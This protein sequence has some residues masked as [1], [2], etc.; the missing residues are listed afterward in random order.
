MLENQST[1]NHQDH[2][3]GFRKLYL[4]E[5]C[6]IPKEVKKDPHLSSNEKIF[7]GEL[8]VLANERGYC[9]GTDPEFSELKGLGER[10]I[11]R[12]FSNMENRGYITRETV[13][14]PY[15]N[16]DGKL[17]WK[18]DRK[19]WI[20][21]KELKKVADTT[22][23]AGS[24][25]RE[26]KKVAD[27]TDMAG[28]F[29]PAK[30]GCIL[31][32]KEKKKNNKQDTPPASPEPA[33]AA[34]SASPHARKSASPPVVVFSVFDQLNIPKTL[35]ESLSSKMDEAKAELLVKRVKAWDNRSSDSCACNSILNKWDTWTDAT[36]KEDVIK[37]NTKW[38]TENLSVLDMRK[39]GT[40]TCYVLSHKIEFTGQ[41]VSVGAKVF[42]CV[43]PTFKSDV[44]I[45]LRNLE[46]HLPDQIKKL[47]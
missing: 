27:T 35:K 20:G 45:F 1:S 17:R 42:E 34:P 18:K 12:Y 40:F 44:T 21:K 31:I 11:Q 9:W 7:F 36:S 43:S 23:M 26:L 6:L 16:D 33:A 37:E 13:I 3:D 47:L 10:T 15:K 8:N 32:G 30:Y 24:L 14:V 29:E 39:F 46:S 19:I 28:S 2:K 5:W 41:G 4:P 22:D 38:M 25:K